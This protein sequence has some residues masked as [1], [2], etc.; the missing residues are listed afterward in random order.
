MGAISVHSEC[1]RRYAASNCRW[2]GSGRVRPVD[3]DALGLEDVSALADREDPYAR[4][5]PSEELLA[6]KHRHVVPGGGRVGIDQDLPTDEEALQPMDLVQGAVHP[7]LKLN[8][9][10]LV[11]LLGQGPVDVPLSVHLLQRI[12]VVLDPGL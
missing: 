8:T 5:H 10:A 6:L 3:L 12:P 1:Q 9:E 7:G 11:D 4:D 2:L